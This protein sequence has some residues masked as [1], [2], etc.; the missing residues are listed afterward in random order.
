[1]AQENKLWGAEKIQGEELVHSNT[2]PGNYVN[3]CSTSVNNKKFEVWVDENGVEDPTFIIDGVMVAQSSKI[4]FLAEFPIQHDKNE[5]CVGGEVFL[6]DDNSPPMIFNIQDLIDSL[7]TSP[8]KYFGD[9]DP[10]QY[11]VNLE[12]PLNVP[13]FSELVNLGFVWRSFL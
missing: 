8:T 2:L 6:T 5:S 13:V 4:P 3:I 1:M 9:F 10:N 7:V 12:Q 11:S